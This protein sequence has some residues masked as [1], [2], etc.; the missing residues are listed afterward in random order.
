MHPFFNFFIGRFK[1]IIYAWKGFKTAATS[2][3]SIILQLIIA[4]LMQLTGWYFNISPTAWILQTLAIGM[5]IA[6][7]MLNTAIEKIADFIHPEYHKKIKIIKDISAGAVFVAAITAII[8]G[9]I[10]YIPLL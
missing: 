9:L 10:I 6:T 5:V 4:L 7:E 3:H 1:G 2:E 8:I